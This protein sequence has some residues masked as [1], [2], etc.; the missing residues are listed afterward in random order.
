MA[1]GHLL[2]SSGRVECQGQQ[3]YYELLLSGTQYLLRFYDVLGKVRV[4]RPIKL[5]TESVEIYGIG[6]YLLCY[7]TRQGDNMS[8]SIYIV[9]LSNL[10]SMIQKFNFDL[11]CH[12][13]E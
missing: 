8:G 12:Q 5:P 9:K 11:Q 10:R 6:E 1:E 13:G 7:E 3:M 4:I 2:K